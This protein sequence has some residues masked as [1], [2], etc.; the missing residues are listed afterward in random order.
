MRYNIKQERAVEKVLNKGL[1][2]ADINQDG[3]KLVGCTGM[4]EAIISLLT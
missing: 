4:G 2:T 3:M 1:R